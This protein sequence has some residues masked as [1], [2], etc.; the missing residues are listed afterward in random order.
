MWTDARWFNFY[1]HTKKHYRFIFET[2]WLR[3]CHRSI[4]VYTSETLQRSILNVQQHFRWWKSTVRI[5][6]N[7]QCKLSNN[8]LV[9]YFWSILNL[10]KQRLN[11]NFIEVVLKHN[12][13]NNMHLPS[14]TR[15]FK[16]ITILYA[17]WHIC[18]TESN[19]HT[20]SGKKF[21]SLQAEVL[22]LI[23]SFKACYFSIDY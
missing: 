1:E 10:S 13:K 21:Y 18:M 8:E 11:C 15:L 12:R 6:W 9:N 23:T 2:T 16:S 4:Y 14:D 17:K 5:H 20:G 7:L 19:Y 22:R 3:L